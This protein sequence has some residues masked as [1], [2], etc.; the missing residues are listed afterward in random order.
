M[1]TMRTLHRPGDYLS[2]F[3]RLLEIDARLRD[4]ERVSQASLAREL[5]VSTRTIQRDF[6]YLRDSLGAPLVYDEHR[7]GWHYAEPAFALPAVLLSETDLHALLLMREALGQY[8]GTPWEAAARRAFGLFER[9]L[10]ERER[11]AANWITSRVAFTGQP[12]A[13]IRAKVW[14]AVLDSLRRSLTL[15]VTYQ[16]PGEPARRRRIDPYGLIVTDGDW[17]LYG[18]DHRSGARRTFLLARI[19]AATVTE[20]TFELP[21]DFDLSRYVREGIDGLQTDGAPV[22]RVRI[23]FSKAASP[24]IAERKWHPDQ[25]EHW[26]RQGRLT[27]EFDVRA[28]FRLERRLQ[29]EQPSIDRVTWSPD[30]PTED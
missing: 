30:K 24:R 2:S 12:A 1:R 15:A 14:D 10:P 18:H 11:F 26:D 21:V 27:V 22:R 16:K 20:R 7:K 17:N 3:G 25:T 29:S 6:A 13:A 8:A 4:G 28:Q 19:R 23:T 9:A 5:G